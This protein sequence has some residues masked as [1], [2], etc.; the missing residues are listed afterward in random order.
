LAEIS[1]IVQ[2][3]IYGANAATE[4]EKYTKRCCEQ[5]RKLLPKSEVILSTWENSDVT[6][7]D[8]D[9][10]VFSKDPGAVVMSLDGIDRPN[11][12]NRMI[13]STKAGLQRAS[14]KYAI[15]M[16]SDMVLE[17]LDFVKKFKN[18]P[19]N[20][21]DCYLE[22]RIISLSANNYL[23]GK[24]VIF[25]I[26]DW[27]EFGYTAD[28]L[29]L[30]DIPLQNNEE[31]LETDGKLRFEDNLVAEAYIWVSFLKKI[32]KY[33]YLS[34]NYKDVVPLTKENID[35]YEQS[36]AEYVVLYNGKQLGLN[37]F[38]LP[39]KNYVR[40]DFAKASCFT[41][42]EWMKLYK[43]HIDR[44]YKVSFILEDYV[45]VVLYKFV[46]K[47]LQKK[48]SGVY[49]FLKERVLNHGKKEYN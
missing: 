24:D 26:S 2:G 46:F 39:N 43:K 29:K 30:W 35:A 17:N 11:N 14:N 42:T 38:K 1:V 34:L 19:V 31:F 36:L 8:A 3:P 25:T 28:L 40:R 45:D 7:I 4:D 20:D 5:I 12:T 41:H 18:F 13:V 47:F 23:R 37:S 27:F 49:M 32:R 33:D 10:V 44:K 48:M 22:Q 16:R 21:S 9:V 6:G 15:K